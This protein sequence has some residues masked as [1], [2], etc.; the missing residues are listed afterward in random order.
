MLS[1][2]QN[3]GQTFYVLFEKTQSANRIRN[4]SAAPNALVIKEAI[5]FLPI[6]ESGAALKIESEDAQFS[7]NLPIAAGTM[8]FH[9]ETKL[10]CRFFYLHTFNLSV[11]TYI[12]R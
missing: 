9:N 4:R 7:T 10:L 1:L 12:P 5:N 8:Q 11:V 3:E 6:G 2:S